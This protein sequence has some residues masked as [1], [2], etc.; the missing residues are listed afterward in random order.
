MG[1]I[2]VLALVLGIP[3]SPTSLSVFSARNGLQGAERTALLAV[4]GYPFQFSVGED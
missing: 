2:T 4:T 3:E 1:V